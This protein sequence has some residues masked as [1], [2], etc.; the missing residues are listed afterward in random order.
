MTKMKT[1]RLNASNRPKTS[2]I[3]DIGGLATESTTPWTTPTVATKECEEK[4]LVAKMVR[5]FVV[6]PSRDVANAIKAILQEHQNSTTLAS[7]SEIVL[8]QDRQHKDP[9]WSMSRRWLLD[10][11]LQPE[12]NLG[13]LQRQSML[14]P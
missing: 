9:S 6:W 11:L 1:E 8:T 3:L 10:A 2:A 4:A 12:H 5:L 7:C 13:F 14:V